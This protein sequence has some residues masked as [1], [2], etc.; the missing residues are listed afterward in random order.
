MWEIELSTKRRQIGRNRKWQ[1]ERKEEC[2]IM[3]WILL[4]FIFAGWRTRTGGNCGGYTDLDCCSY[5]FCGEKETTFT[6][7]S[8][9]KM[10][11]YG[12]FCLSL[13][14]RS[15]KWTLPGL[16]GFGLLPKKGYVPPSTLISSNLSDSQPQMGITSS[17]TAWCSTLTELEDP[18]CPPVLEH[19]LQVLPARLNWSID[20]HLGKNTGAQ[21]YELTAVHTTFQGQQNIQRAAPR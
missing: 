13:H 18:H 7:V 11:D 14:Y 15:K 10:C 19:C 17:Q 12:A 16:A 9:C 4:K 8:G 3:I 5:V 2:V 6:S 1:R 21:P 20:P